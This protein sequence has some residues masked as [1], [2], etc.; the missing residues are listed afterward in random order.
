M[1]NII[2]GNAN[3]LS[4]SDDSSNTDTLHTL[5]FPG[6]RVRSRWS[7]ASHRNGPGIN[8]A[9]LPGFVGLPGAAR[10]LAC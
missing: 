10:V 7:D 5:R 4:V 9:H 6:S 3:N 8:P 1:T 2:L